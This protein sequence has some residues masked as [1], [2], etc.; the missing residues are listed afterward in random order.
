MNKDFAIYLQT[1]AEVTTTQ[2]AQLE[3]KI[4]QRTISK[5][6]YVLRKGDTCKQVFYV[7]KGLL[8]FYSIDH[9]GKEHII[10]FAPEGWF[11]SDRSSIYF[12]EPSEY[13]IDAIEESTVVTMDD[14]FV[15]TLSEMSPSFTKYNDQLL[16]KH[17]RHLQKRINLLIG[18]TAEERYLDFIKSYPD[19]TQRVPQWMIASYLGITPES[20]SRVRKE[21]VKKS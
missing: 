2:L 16:Q 7:E 20:L 18:A 15:C 1:N 17:I 3:K 11:I 8:R 13:Y 6:E 9:F 21:L 14:Q 5:G 19:L 4:V 12:N 10:Q